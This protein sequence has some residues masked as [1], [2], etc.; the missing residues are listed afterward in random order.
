M[1]NREKCLEYQKEYNKSNFYKIQKY[2]SNYWNENK[3]ELLMKRKDYEKNNR[4]QMYDM[5]T[6]WYSKNI[7]GKRFQQLQ[8]KSV[9]HTQYKESEEKQ[10]SSEPKQENRF[11]YT[12]QIIVR[13]D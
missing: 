2:Y 8:I 11:S 4:W 1:K 5:R 10:A 6:K 7:K 12:D 9:W 3:D 13:F